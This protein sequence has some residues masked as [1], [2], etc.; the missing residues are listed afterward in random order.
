MKNKLKEIKNTCMQTQ[1]SGRGLF[2]DSQWRVEE[3]LHNTPNLRKT[4][5]RQVFSLL[6]WDF[7]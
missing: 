6:S 7:R 1:H 2:E 3:Y 5:V 4:E